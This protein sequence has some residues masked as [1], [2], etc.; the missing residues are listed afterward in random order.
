VVEQS[1]DLGTLEQVTVRD[2]T[3]VGG[4]THRFMRLRLQQH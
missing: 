3:P 2:L 4:T 1:V